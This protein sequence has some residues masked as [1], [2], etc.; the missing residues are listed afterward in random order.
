MSRCGVPVLLQARHEARLVVGRG[1]DEEAMRVADSHQ[2]HMNM[3]E[4][5]ILCQ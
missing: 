4:I 5:H 3:K 1:S 2:S